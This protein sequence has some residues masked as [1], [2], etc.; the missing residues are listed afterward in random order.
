MLNLTKFRHIFI[1]TSFGPTPSISV[2]CSFTSSSNP[3]AHPSSSPAVAIFWDL[4]NKP[5][6]S[7]PPFDAA[8]RLKKAAQKFGFVKYM[9]AYANRHSFAYVPPLVRDQRRERKTLNELEKI[10]AIKPSEPYTCGVCGRKFYK[11]EKLMNHFKDIHEREQAKR[12]NQIE[13]SRG[14]KRVRL[15]AKYAMKMEKYKRAA[16][17]V[18][19]PKTGYGLADEVK[20]AGFWVREVSNLPQA[21]DVALRN[22][23]VELM[24][25]RVMD[26]LVLVSDDSDFE[27]VLKEARE[28]C[29]KTVVVG[30]V[31]EGCLKRTA[32]SSFSWEEILIGKARKQAVSVVGKWKDFSVLKGLEWTYDPER[33][34]KSYFEE[35][36]SRGSDF[37][38]SGSDDESGSGSVLGEG[39][40]WWEMESDG[41][42]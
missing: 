17:D 3:I 2:C 18:L 1:K 7:S 31:S 33:E 23:M 40:D 24:D 28:R 21:A 8:I 19:T 39:G 30:D 16:R 9:I 32:N 10:G 15:V 14:K 37:E 36:E 20:R 6:K 22:H 5:P 35:I 12:V 26:C 25:R 38:G 13:S 29:L 11:N 34:K 4:D 42:D 27:G 41:D